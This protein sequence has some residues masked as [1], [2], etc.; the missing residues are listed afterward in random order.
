MPVPLRADPPSALPG[1]RDGA[2]QFGPGAYV[3]WRATSLG[4][5]TEALEQRLI[6][7]LAAEIN[8]RAV[9]D[10][11]CGDGVLALV[12]CQN[13]AASVV[14]CDVDPQMIARARTR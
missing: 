7:R 2:G 5:I 1:R 9:L 14:G 12:F 10:I 8:G 11:G 4:N 3:D 6:L 13:G